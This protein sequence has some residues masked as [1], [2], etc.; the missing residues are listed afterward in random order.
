M[1]IEEILAT[2]QKHQI[3]VTEANKANKETLLAALSA[4]GI[5]SVN[6]GFDGSC[7]SG[8]IEAIAVFSGDSIVDLPDS[9]KLTIREAGYGANDS[10][11]RE[12]SLCEAIEDI[13]YGYL[14]QEHGGWENN[15]GAYGD[16]T[17]HVARRVIELDFNARYTNST[18]YSYEF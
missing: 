15:D 2:M 11:T 4:L 13:C 8:Q 9:T 16:F 3:L 12:C 17:F 7:D 14:Q 6:V 5:T 1:S 18:N 10:R